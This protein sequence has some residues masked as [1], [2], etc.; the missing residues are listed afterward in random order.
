MATRID[1]DLDE[2]RLLAGEVRDF[3]VPMWEARH[4]EL[5]AWHECARDTPYPHS[6]PSGGMCRW[7]SIVLAKVLR[8]ATGHPWRLAGGE[9]W[10]PRL[11]TGGMRDPSG[12]W[13]GHY[14]VECGDALVDVAADQFGH[15]AVI[16]ERGVHPLHDAN[17]TPAE[18]RGHVADSKVTADLWLRAWRGRPEPDGPIPR[19]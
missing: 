19:P 9:P 16:V 6:L 18:I 17:Y 10:P 3:L 12:A 4:A 2:V 1:I 15:D 7:T 8:D 14:W 5:R 13:R 11:P